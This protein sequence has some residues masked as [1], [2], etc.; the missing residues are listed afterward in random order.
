VHV[1]TQLLV[2][3]DSAAFYPPD[4]AGLTLWATACATLRPQ[5]KRIGERKEGKRQPPRKTTSAPANRAA[6]L[7]N[8]RIT[9][10]LEKR[11][12][13]STRPKARTWRMLDPRNVV[14]LTTFPPAS[15]P[16]SAWSRR[17]RRFL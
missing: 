10:A 14:N 16:T 7:E 11:L 13:R 12:N 8:P 6:S 2:H 15:S 9:D 5:M 3:L 1:I 17:Q 4:G